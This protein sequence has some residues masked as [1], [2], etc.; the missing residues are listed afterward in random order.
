MAAK[1]IWDYLSA[2]TIAP[3]YDAILDVSPQSV[4]VEDGYKNQVIQ[5]GDDN[6]D[7]VISFSDDSIFFVR[8]QWNILKEADAGTIFD[9]YHDSTKANAMARTFKWQD[10]GVSDIH[11]YTVRFASKV[12]RSI[13]LAQLFGFAEVRLKIEG[14]AP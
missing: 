4:I 3:D 13:K 14:R 7:A 1:E 2:T 8:L 12:T 6:S 5:L 9:F 10:H 11:T